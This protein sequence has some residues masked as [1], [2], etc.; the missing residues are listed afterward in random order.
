[1]VRLVLLLIGARALRRRWPLLVAAGVLWMAL[2]SL[3]IGDVSADGTL[4][5][6]FESL[7]VLL[8]LEGLGALLGALGMGVRAAQAAAWRGAIL[9]VLG[10]L[11]LR[12]FDHGLPDALLFGLAFLADGGLRVASAWVVR[13]SGWRWALAAGLAELA[14]AVLVLASWPVPH[15]VLVPFCFGVALLASGWSLARLGVEL[16]RLPRG[17]SLTALPLY[18]TRRWAVRDALPDHV[19]HY[20][21]PE[22]MTLYVWTPTG[23]AEDPR[24]QLL[25]DRYIAAVD[26]DGDISTGHSALEVLPDVYISHYPAVEID[27]KPDDFTRIL[28]AGPE[29]DIAGR[30]QPNHAFEVAHWCEADAKVVFP[31]YDATALRAFWDVYRADST[32]NL[33]SRSCSTVTSLAIES[34]LEGIC[35]G[36]WPLAKAFWLALDPRVWLAAILRRRGATMAWTPGLILDY[37]R[38]LEGI[39]ERHAIGRQP[40]AHRPGDRAQAVRPS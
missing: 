31:R 35:G 2:G 6:A 27:H 36:R 29:N 8:V 12:P 23:S 26:K 5:I 19:P 16:R 17:A 32:Y 28:R 7:A 39:V 40:R 37:A 30:W 25:I 11:L 10:V 33:T 22:P 24:R 21:P 14:L 3:L 9:L 18:A 38:V 1:M 13:F 15:T 4:S 20:D 34:A